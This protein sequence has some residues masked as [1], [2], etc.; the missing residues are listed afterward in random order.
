MVELAMKTTEHMKSWN[1]VVLLLPRSLFLNIEKVLQERK[2]A[3]AATTTKETHS[4]SQKAKQRLMAK[5]KWAKFETGLNFGTDG[6][7]G[8]VFEFEGKSRNFR[9]LF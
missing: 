5:S 8:N 9:E 3:A 6:P 4:L 1:D 2:A 7:M